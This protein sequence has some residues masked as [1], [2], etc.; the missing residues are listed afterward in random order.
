MGEAV[1]AFMKKMTLQQSV[2]DLS[3]L[4]F[5]DLDKALKDAMADV[6]S[7]RDFLNGTFSFQS[8]RSRFSSNPFPE[9]RRRSLTINAL[10]IPS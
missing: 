3:E 2:V 5:A 10:P 6:L 4:N 7:R 9:H 1:Q 8:S